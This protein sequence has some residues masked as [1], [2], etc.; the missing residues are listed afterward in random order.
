MVVEMTDTTAPRIDVDA[1]RALAEPVVADIVWATATTVGPDDR[2]RSRIVHPVLE[3]TP[4]PLGWIT[5][6]P[7]PLKR[8]HL[9]AHPWLTL[10][11]WSP[12][13]NCVYLDCDATWLDPSR[14]AE[15]WE[16]IRSTPAPL[17]FD[18]ATIWPDGPGST[19]FAVILLRP[20]RV[21]VVMAAAMAA[22]E[23]API[24]EATA[25]SDR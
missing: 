1:L 15:A 2:P 21:R 17:G 14:H 3:W 18:P 5:T 10:S 16:R 24:W 11:Y 7:T 9:A 22:G 19:D 8:R 23:P 13:Q 12:T 6:R 25:P 20:L 4:E